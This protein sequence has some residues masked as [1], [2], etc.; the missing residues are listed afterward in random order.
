MS[1][2]AVLL[3]I[4]LLIGHQD[5]SN[6]TAVDAN[7][8]WSFPVPEG[9]YGGSYYQ[10]MERVNA[11]DQKGEGYELH[12]QILRALSRDARYL[13]AVLFQI[14]TSADG[15]HGD[16][17]FLKINTNPTSSSGEDGFPLISQLTTEVWNNLGIRFMGSTSDALDVKLLS[18][19]EDLT[20]RGYTA[21]AA[22]Y[23]IIRE[24]G[25]DNRYVG[26]VIIYRQSNAMTFYLSTPWHVKNQRKDEMWMM[27]Q[28]IQ[29]SR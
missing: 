2:K 15:S 18:H 12:I 23:K 1:I 21:A 7:G 20:I 16:A 3:F 25:H 13:D 6:W 28:R 22:N 5:T 10:I 26:L 29:F 27:L 24:L 9:W 17:S 8:R 19:R 14:E 4:G 11:A